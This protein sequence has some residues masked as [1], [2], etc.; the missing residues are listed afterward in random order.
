[1]KAIF[2]GAQP[3][4]RSGVPEDVAEAALW[5]AG[6]NSS[7]VSGHALVVDGGLSGGRVWSD[8]LGAMDNIGS[9]MGRNK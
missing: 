6:D 7:F 5:L 1:V 3:I 2:A 8:W 9:L 4:K